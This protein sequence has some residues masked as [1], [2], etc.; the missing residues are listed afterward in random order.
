MD[1]RRRR[2]ALLA[3]AAAVAAPAA[4]AGDARPPLRAMGWAPADA[5]PRR[6]FATAPVECLRPAPDPTTA[7]SV[8]VGRAAFRSPLLLGGQAA[9]AGLSCESCHR[10]G[11][12]NPDFQF[13]G[14]SGPPGTADVTHA[15]F[16]SR[17]GNGTHDPKPIPDLGGPRTRLKVAAADLQPFIR[18]LVVEEFDGAEPPKAVLEGLAAYVRGL[19]PAACPPGGRAPVTLRGLLDD[20]RRAVK[21]ATAVLRAGDRETAAMMV[22]AARAQLGL[23]DERYAGLAPERARLRTS[24]AAL[25]QAQAQIRAGATGAPARLADWLAAAPGLEAALAVRERRSLFDP[26]RLSAAANRR[27][28]REAS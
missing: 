8:E 24:D 20:S 19:D 4:L 7:L 3:L 13:P 11:R 21:A 22:G 1:R 12:D 14:V 23:V 17:R 16:S 2:A 26:A 6:A 15:L 10:A 5:D 18:G 25:A 9:R 28:P 27:L